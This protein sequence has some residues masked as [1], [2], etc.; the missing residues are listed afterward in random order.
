MELIVRTAHG[1]A[2]VSI[3][4]HDSDVP[5]RDV[6]AAVT[7]QAAPNTAR[8]DG[9]L[10]NAGDPVAACGVVAGSLID[11]LLDDCAEA[12]TAPV[13]VLRQLTGPGAG[14]R[15]PLPLGRFRIGSLSG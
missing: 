13:I 11:T 3:D 7:G 14:R 10:V 5:L 2:D 8:V 6:I 12:T 15:V 9:R 4:V 1:T